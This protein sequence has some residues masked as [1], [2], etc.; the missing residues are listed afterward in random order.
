MPK[1]DGSYSL[2]VR[3]PNA[4]KEKHLLLS[5]VRFAYRQE[6]LEEALAC[7]RALSYRFLRDEK[8][9]RAFVSME[10]SPVK[11]ISDRRLGAIGIDINPDQLVVA[12]LERSG[13]FTGGGASLY[14]LRQDAAEQAKDILGNVAKEAVE[15]AA[16]C[17]QTHGDRTPGLCRQKGSSGR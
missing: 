10:P 8:G 3:L 1:E 9:W 12:E 17:L 6:E 4:M 2:R 7:G 13:N 11:P 5:G 15:R 14:Y 16:S